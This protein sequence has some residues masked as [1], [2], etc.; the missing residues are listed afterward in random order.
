MRILCL[1]AF[2]LL[3]QSPAFC[4]TLSVP[5]DFPTIQQAIDGAVAGDRIMVDRGTYF[6]NIDF[7]G[8]AISVLSATGPELT[9]I[10]GR[11]KGSVVT[12]TTWEGSDSVLEGFT[13]TNGSGTSIVYY[14]KSYKCGGGIFC[15]AYTSP[16]I[17]NNLLCK[18]KADD[19]GGAIFCHIKSSPKICNNTLYENESKSGGG[20]YCLAESAP[21]IIENTLFENRAHEGGA[22]YCDEACYATIR[23]NVI[24][25]N[26]AGEGYDAIEGST[27][28]T[29]ILENSM[30]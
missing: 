5:G 18:N 28:T 17:K 22:V 24:G 14:D 19:W 3:F 1:I 13:I 21:L 8:K 7:K 15:Q 9:I 12:F 30:E 16:T 10:D 23:K 4:E 26:S 25:E 6:E 11:Q 29:T 27:T 20:I 2:V